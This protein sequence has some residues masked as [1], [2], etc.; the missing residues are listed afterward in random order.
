MQ[1]DPRCFACSK[2]GNKPID[3]KHKDKNE[4]FCRDCKFEDQNIN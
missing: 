4:F 1:I 3:F 2:H